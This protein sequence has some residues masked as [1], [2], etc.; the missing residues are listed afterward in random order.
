MTVAEVVDNS[1]SLSALLVTAVRQADLVSISKGHK[2]QHEKFYHA[3]DQ[4]LEMGL[5]KI[6]TFSTPE[7]TESL[8]GQGS[9]QPPEIPSNL[10][11]SMV[12]R[13]KLLSD[14]KPTSP[15]VEYNSFI[16][17]HCNRPHQTKGQF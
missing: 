4:L 3:C 17:V 12:L 13:T 7:D 5:S 2:L 8:S 6:E 14:I 16:N 10:C 9:E 11:H 1:L 15:A